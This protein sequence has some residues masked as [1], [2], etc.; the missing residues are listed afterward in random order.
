MQVPAHGREKEMRRPVSS[1]TGATK[2]NSASATLL[3]EKS[4]ST[5]TNSH[6]FELGRTLSYSQKAV[7]SLLFH[8]D[9]QGPNITTAI[10][11]AQRNRMFASSELTKIQ[12]INLV[13]AIRDAV[14]WKDRDPRCAI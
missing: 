5:L 3:A 2:P 10:K 1:K 11:A 12:R 4:N 13:S 6:G 9:A 14:V 8:R 7:Q